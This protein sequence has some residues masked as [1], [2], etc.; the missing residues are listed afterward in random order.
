MNKTAGLSAFQRERARKKYK[1]AAGPI[2]DQAVR[3][4]QAGIAREAQALCL[5]IL[6]NLPDHFDALHLLGVSKLGAKE[7][8]EAEAFLQRA[9]E[10]DSRSADALSDLGLVQLERRQFDKAR[11][12]YE[13]AIVL[14]PNSPRLTPL[15]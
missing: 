5:Q 4:H 3:L 13:R 8:E 9:V 6:E 12:N 14:R 1:K 7:L 10:I 2:F 15:L 11:T